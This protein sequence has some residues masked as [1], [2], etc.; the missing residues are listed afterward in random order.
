MIPS[1]KKK[2]EIKNF[3]CRHKVVVCV[4]LETRAR[5]QNAS[6]VQ[7]KIGKEWMWVNNYSHSPIG[8]I[9]IGW[10]PAWVNVT[11]KH[12]QDQF[13]VC[14]IQDQ[15]HHV[16]LVAMYG[17]HT[18]ANR[19]GLWRGLLEYVQHQEPMIVIGDFNAVCQTNDRS[20]GALI[21]DA[22]I[23]DFQNFLLQSSLIENRSIG[24]FYSWSNSSV[25][26]DRVVSRIDKAFV[27]Q[28]WIRMYAEVVVQYS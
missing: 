5:E 11:L 16:N 23:E 13:M 14:S 27:N 19:R 18:I 28:A 24:P 21:S 10:R 7:K 17:L 12:A 22:E 3:L 25:G 1:K 26:S 9:W 20:N 8:R 4:L 2:K 6:K 15:V